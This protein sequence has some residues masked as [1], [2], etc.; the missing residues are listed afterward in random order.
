MRTFDLAMC[1]SSI[2]SGRVLAVSSVCAAVSEQKVV[3][4][5]GCCD[6]L[7]LVADALHH[8]LARC[9]TGTAT[10]RHGETSHTQVRFI[11]VALRRAADLYKW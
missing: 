7:S 4:R 2:S 6:E 5:T 3:S 8:I 1:A 10:R 9:D 11:W